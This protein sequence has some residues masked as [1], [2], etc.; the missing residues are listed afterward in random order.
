ME[1]EIEIDYNRSSYTMW[2]NPPTDILSYV[3]LVI[4][5]SCILVIITS[6]FNINYGLNISILCIVG[7]I[8]FVIFNFSKFNNWRDRNEMLSKSNVYNSYTQ[9]EEEQIKSES[10]SMW[11]PPTDILSYV[12]L[13][14]SSICILVIIIS[15]F[16]INYGVIISILCI[17]G[18]ILFVM[19]NFSKFNNPRDSN[20]I[21]SKSNVIKRIKHKLYGLYMG[22]IMSMVSR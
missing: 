15:M 18:S 1:E 19:L 3:D 16:N 11:N 20:E 2:K 9:M 12:D 17:V 7:S 8:L 6:M 5:S 4:L 14:I 21:L 13:V 22:S 10:Y